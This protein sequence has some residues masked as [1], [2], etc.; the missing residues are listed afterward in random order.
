MTIMVED[1]WHALDVDIVSPFQVKSVS[2]TKIKMSKF[3]PA[4]FCIQTNW[5]FSK[6]IWSTAYVKRHLLYLNA[7]EM[8]KHPSS[9]L[10]SYTLDIY[11]LK[12][13]WRISGSLNI[14]TIIELFNKGDDFGKKTKLPK[15]NRKELLGHGPAKEP[16][17]RADQRGRWGQI[18]K[19]LVRHITF[20]D[21]ML[22]KC[23]YLQT[24]PFL[25]LLIFQDLLK[26][27]TFCGGALITFLGASSYYSVPWKCLEII[28]TST[29]SCLLT[30]SLAFLVSGIMADSALYL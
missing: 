17:Q 23:L 30:C 16:V 5:I 26:I 1:S 9:F 29:C 28:F 25:L 20:C 3:N 24:S 27:T 14:A 18:R 8:R 13:D 12:W 10:K 2:S 6:Y 22:Y 19:G 7:S 4:S 11:L 15:F 21:L